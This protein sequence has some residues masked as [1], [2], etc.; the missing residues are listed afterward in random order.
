[1]MVG[2]ETLAA[3]LFGAS[4]TS[5]QQSRSDW[6]W[7]ELSRTPNETRAITFRPFPLDPDIGDVD[8]TWRVNVTDIPT[9][10]TE[11]SWPITY[12]SRTK[13]TPDARGI[14]I[15]YSLSWSPAG[16][17]TTFESLLTTPRSPKICA[18]HLYALALLARNV[19]NAYNA[20]EGCASVLTQPC[21]DAI[22]S[23]TTSYASLN[24]THCSPGNTPWHN[25]PECASTLGYAYHQ[26]EPRGWY[27]VMSGTTMMPRGNR[28][29]FNWIGP[30]IYDSSEERAYEKGVNMLHV[31]LVHS[32]ALSRA[33]LSEEEVEVW[34][35]ARRRPFLACLRVREEEVDEGI[36]TS[37]V[38]RGDDDVEEGQG[39]D[40]DDDDDTSAAAAAR[41][42]GV[43]C[44]MWGV[45]GLAAVMWFG[46][47][48]LLIKGREV[49]QRV[50]MILFEGSDRIIIVIV[51][52][53]NLW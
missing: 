31:L 32:N 33:G 44:A 19:T 5:A 22:L 13:T 3:L 11:T 6:N 21:V 34:E 41:L 17:S 28:E 30:L 15:V 4:L 2:R 39:R 18:T 49:L 29:G 40:G 43:N 1:M 7:T 16:N 46:L 36:Y 42:T 25:L 48:A 47:S 37:S 53:D 12:P 9:P 35:R 10:N 26:Q 27:G 14:D 38:Q 23:Q 45:L 20:T 50:K 8:F 51:I 52:V 24:A